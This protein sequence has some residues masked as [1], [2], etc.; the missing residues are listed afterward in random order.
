MTTSFLLIGG[1]S[2]GSVVDVLP[3]GYESTGRP[4]SGV[5]GES[6][7]LAEWTHDGFSLMAHEVIAASTHLDNLFEARGI[8]NDG[9]IPVVSLDDTELMDAIARVQRAN[10]RQ[11]EWLDR[12]VQVERSD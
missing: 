10:Q 8:P 3:A 4:S 12:N 7:I 9:S 6:H 11:M 1:P 2:T 5:G